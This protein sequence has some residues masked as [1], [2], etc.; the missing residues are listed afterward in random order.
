M[1]R[2]YVQAIRRKVFILCTASY[3]ILFFKGNIR[4]NIFYEEKTL[5][6]LQKKSRD[7]CLRDFVLI[8]SFTWGSIL[9]GQISQELQTGFAI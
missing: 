2:F 5:H 1:N 9:G 3:S 7:F 6:L 8:C 4:I